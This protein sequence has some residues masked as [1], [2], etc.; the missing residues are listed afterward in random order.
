MLISEVETLTAEI[1]QLKCKL[2]AHA[3]ED[4]DEGCN[5]Y[6]TNRRHHVQEENAELS[7]ELSILIHSFVTHSDLADRRK[8]PTC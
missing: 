4:D 1:K 8:F 3:K 6:S 2:M 7:E 5:E